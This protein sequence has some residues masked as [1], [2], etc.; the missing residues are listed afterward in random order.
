MTYRR[1]KEKIKALLHLEDSTHRLTLSFSLGVFVAFSPLIGF[2]TLIALA[3]GWIFRLNI[4]AL[5]LG[6][7][8]N[9]PWT[10]FPI[11]GGSL[12]LGL[13]LGIGEG[14]VPP[15]VWSDVSFPTF[16]VQLKPYVL[17]LF[18]GSSILGAV[19]SLVA[20]PMAFF[21]IEQARRRLREVRESHQ[22]QANQ[23]RSGGRDLP[24]PPDETGMP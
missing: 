3:I 1:L 2:H 12:W 10:F 11:I 9:N 5:L 24:V 22:S 8:L 14:A 4:V 15:L 23:N 19:F 20:Y 21:L 7:L 17:P 16:W 18:V 6:A 13:K